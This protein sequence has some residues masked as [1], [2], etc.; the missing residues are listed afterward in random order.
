MRFVM[1]TRIGK[2]ERERGDRERFGNRHYDNDGEGSTVLDAI[3][4]LGCDQQ[5]R[6]R[7][8]LAVMCCADPACLRS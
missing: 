8:R 6:L 7:M 4:V 2:A 5:I 1:G 3:S